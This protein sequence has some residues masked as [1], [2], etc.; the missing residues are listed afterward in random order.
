MKT[1]LDCIPCFFKQALDAS[2]I[3][4]AD[5][6]TQ[7]QI[8][9]EVARVVPEFRLDTSPPEMARTIYRTVREKTGVDDP[10]AHIKEESNRFAL[11]IHDQL[12]RKVENSGDPLFTA[13][14]LAIAGNIIDYGAK[15][16]LNVDEELE[17]ILADEQQAIEHEEAGLFQ[18]DA[19]LGAL[20]KSKHI[21]YLADNAGEIVFDRVL[22]EVIRQQY[23]HIKIWFA[24]KEKPAI[25]DA[26]MKDAV[27]C[28]LHEVAEVISS[29]SDA[30]GTLL[31]HCSESFLKIFKTADMVISKGQG[32]FE[33]LSGTDR[34]IFFLLLAKCP[35]IADHI[36]CGVGDVILLNH[37][38]IL[39][40]KRKG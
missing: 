16:T 8:L 10:Y 3:A 34:Q 2:R 30:P 5:A 22:L 21:L 31:E 32:N 11:N 38:G 6:E 26:L 4:G 33:T 39:L 24:V 37:Q 23:P 29:G 27:M 35:I 25:N 40:E 20:K 17:K 9:N 13:V 1:Y 18:D 7:R 12:I 28:G 19:F 15:N 14:E 36:G